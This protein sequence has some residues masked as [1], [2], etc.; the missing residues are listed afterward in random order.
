MTSPV[1]LQ[2]FGE[3]N[4][5]GDSDAT[6]QQDRSGFVGM[7][8]KSVADG[9]DAIEFV[10][11]FLVPERLQA[12]SHYL[13]QYLDPTLLRICTHYGERPPHGDRVVTL[14][15][16]KGSGFRSRGTPGCV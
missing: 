14:Q 5:R 8:R 1:A 12:L 9:A 10:P 11:H 13:E 3:E 4:H 7:Q 15:M 6:S 2:L 16:D